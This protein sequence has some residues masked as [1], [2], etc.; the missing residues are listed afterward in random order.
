MDDCGMKVN[1]FASRQLFVDQSTISLYNHNLREVIGLLSIQNVWLEMKDI[2]RS[3]RQRINGE[4]EPLG[5][6]S[7]EGDILFHLLTGCNHLQQEQLADR[8]D[9]GKAAVSRAVDSLE[10]KGYVER[11]RQ[12]KDRRAYGITLTDKTVSAGADIVGIY[13]RLYTLVKKGISEEE[14]GQIEALL[15]RVAAN[16][17]SPGDQ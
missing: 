12:Q 15:S 9:I 1:D 3:A 8:L 7:A 2:L 10:A 5:L 4:L 11:I 6:S 14:F 16:L 17:Q 13:E